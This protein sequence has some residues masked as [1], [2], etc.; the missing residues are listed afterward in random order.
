M[1]SGVSNGFTRRLLEDTEIGGI[2]FKKDTILDNS[3]I[4]FMYSPKYF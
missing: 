3:W 4:N 2:L 1:I